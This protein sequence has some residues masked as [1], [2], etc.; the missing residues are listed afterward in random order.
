MPKI[1]YTPKKFNPTHL[2]I[3]EKAN[4]IIAGYATQGY[5]LTLRQVY[6]QFISRNWF[7]DSW[8]DPKTNSANN[9]R[10]YDKLGSIISDA[11]RAGKIDWE[12]IV[13]RTRNV[14]SPAAWAGPE[15]IVAACAKQ[16]SIDFWKGQPYRPEVWVEKDALVGVL[17]VACRPWHCAYFSCRGYTS[18]SEIW[19]AAQRLKGYATNNQTP[20]VFHLGDHDPSGVDMSRDIKD[21]LNLFAGGL[22]VPIEV[23]RI[24]LNMDQVHQY[25][26]PPNPAKTTDGRYTKYAEEY[27]TESWELDALDPDV[28]AAL[29]E[30]EMLAI[31]DQAEWAAAGERRAE[32]RR[33]LTAVSDDWDTLTEGL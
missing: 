32:G 18:D 22:A 12:A 17:E 14:R 19:S 10:S 9:D 8:I 11:R 30:T 6:Y 28:I 3:I 5:D 7:P 29:I 15:E 25:N 20:I 31:V 23:K 13:D 33:L 16:F 24:A 21:R 2:D 27:G 26:P 1:C 4:Q